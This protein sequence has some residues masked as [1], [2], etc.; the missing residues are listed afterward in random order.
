MNTL[1]VQ[2]N[3]KLSFEFDKYASKNPRVWNKIPN[4]SLVI[5][6][7]KGD[8]AFN[9][10]SGYSAGKVKG[11]NQKV[12]QAIKEHNTWRVLNYNPA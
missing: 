7:I 5:F 10:W 9:T 2:K 11:K 8:D 6:T 4:G 12:I 1:F 3:I